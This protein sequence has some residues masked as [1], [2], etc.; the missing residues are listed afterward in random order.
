MINPI[1]QLITLS[2]EYINPDNL[3]IINKN[4]P[5]ATRDDI[6]E[7]YQRRRFFISEFRTHLTS[8]A[9]L[10]EEIEYCNCQLKRT[11][12]KESARNK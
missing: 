6:L 5:I 11:L 12:E 4:H 1:R 3:F 8:V 7:L 9:E 2:Y 10:I